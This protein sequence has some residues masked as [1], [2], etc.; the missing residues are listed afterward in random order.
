MKLPYSRY[1]F[2]PDDKIDKYLLSKT[3]DTGKHKAHMLNKVGFDE[4]NKEE[5]K[6]KLLKIG[7]SNDV[8]SVREIINKGIHYGKSYSI[9]GVLVGPKGSV[10]VIAAWKILDGKRKPCLVTVGHYSIIAL[11]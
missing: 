1:A 2:I 6:L 8:L 9:K 7:R 5:L 4:N 3:H 10:E 11:N